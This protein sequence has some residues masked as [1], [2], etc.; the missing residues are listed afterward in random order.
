[1]EEN[2]K[3]VIDLK[4]IMIILEKEREDIENEA[5]SRNNVD[6]FEQV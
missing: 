2:Q 1:M 4:E 5:T 6:I 3:P